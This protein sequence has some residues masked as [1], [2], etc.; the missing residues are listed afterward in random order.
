DV[1]SSDLLYFSS[2]TSHIISSKFLF[3][4]IFNSLFFAISNIARKVATIYSLFNTGN[5]S[6]KETF[7]FF[8]NILLISNLLDE[9]LISLVVTFVFNGFDS[10]FL[11]R[12]FLNASTKSSNVISDDNFAFSST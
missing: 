2:C 5:N 11:S 4:V 8:F 3:W 12:Y 9:T 1:C 7:G 6:K 10:F